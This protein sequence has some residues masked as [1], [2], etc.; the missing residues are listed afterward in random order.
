M[1]KQKEQQKSERAVIVVM[2]VICYLLLLAVLFLLFVRLP[3]Y[4]D[5]NFEYLITEEIHV[6]EL[7]SWT[8]RGL[9]LV[10]ESGREFPLTNRSRRLGEEIGYDQDEIRELLEN[11]QVEIAYLKDAMFVVKLR[12][13][14]TELDF[15]ALAKRSCQE[16]QF[17]CYA[18]SMLIFLM[19]ILCTAACY[20]EFFRPRKK[21]KRKK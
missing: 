17:G 18:V 7:Y 6:K 21:K 20:W 8:K 3:Q 14:D 12:V 4:A 5:E 1:G 2:T 15:T 11:Q 9:G 16:Q 10:D 13:G 19:A